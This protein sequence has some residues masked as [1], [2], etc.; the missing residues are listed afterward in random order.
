MVRSL[1]TRRYGVPTPVVR[2]RAYDSIFRARRIPRATYIFGD[3]E[4]LSPWELTIASDVYRA[5]QTEGLRC[6]NDPARAMARVELLTTLHDAGINPVYV[7]RADAH[8]QPPR[9]PVFLRAENDHRE[10]SAALYE[11]QAELDAALTRLRS[12]GTPL[13]GMLVVE[14]VSEAYSD[15]LWAK[16]GTYRIGDQFVTEHIAVENMWLVKIGDHAKVTEAIARDENQAVMT[17]RFAPEL[18]PAFELG[19]IEY[20]RADHATV[21]GKTVIYEINTNPSLTR[22]KPS[23]LPVRRETQITAR[24]RIAAAFAA[25]DTTA[26]GKV[27]IPETPL[28]QPLRW[29]IPGFR[30]PRRP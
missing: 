5:M 28:R 3:L 26:G 2:A 30:P 9:F 11:N 8:P 7:A 1:E 4:R 10:A 19:G 20:G 24:T 22:F 29:W 14:K 17:G 27:R 21:S 25:I 16:W 13:R 15:N 23:A 6:L 18:R 12:S